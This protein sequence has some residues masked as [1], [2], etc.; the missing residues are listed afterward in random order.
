LDLQR[1]LKVLGTNSKLPKCFSDD[2]PRL[3]TREEPLKLE[4]LP[5]NFLAKVLFFG[6]PQWGLVGYER[7]MIPLCLQMIPLCLQTSSVDDSSAVLCSPVLST[8]PIPLPLQGFLDSS[9]GLCSVN[10]RSIR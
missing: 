4:S 2:L 9:A 10:Q 7:S 3:L 6:L 5:N 8:A 1:L